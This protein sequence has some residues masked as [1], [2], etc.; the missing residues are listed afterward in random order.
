VLLVLAHPLYDAASWDVRMFD[1][2]LTQWNDVKGNVK[3]YVLTLI[4]AGIALGAKFI[5]D[6]LPLCI[7]TSAERYQA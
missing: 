1:W 6:S 5:T 4:T 2:L 3:F 7:E